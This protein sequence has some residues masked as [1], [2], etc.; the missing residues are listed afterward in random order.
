MS[1]KKMKKIAKESRALM[2]K[3]VKGEITREEYREAVG[4]DA[5]PSVSLKSSAG[6]AYADIQRLLQFIFA[7]VFILCCFISSH[8]ALPTSY[9]CVPWVAT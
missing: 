4:K 7:K 9:Q 5:K 3:Y 6:L 1:R 8:I 2:E